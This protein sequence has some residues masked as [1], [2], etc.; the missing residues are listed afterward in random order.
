MS[1]NIY[2]LEIIAFLKEKQELAIAEF[3]NT[4]INSNEEFEQSTRW[5]ASIYRI[6]NENYPKYFVKRLNV[7]EDDNGNILRVE[8]EY[9]SLD[10]G[11]CKP[12]LCIHSELF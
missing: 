4:D 2:L 10:K 3:E 6:V 1:D 8:Y 12:S 7:Y 9:F 11:R 5:F